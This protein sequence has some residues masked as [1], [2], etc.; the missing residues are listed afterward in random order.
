[1]RVAVLCAERGTVPA[2]PPELELAL[3]DG[4]LQAVEGGSGDVRVLVAQLQLSFS[5]AGKRLADS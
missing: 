4:D 5:K 3:L 2:V 1:M